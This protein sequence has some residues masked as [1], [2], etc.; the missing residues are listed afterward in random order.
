[1]DGQ[2]YPF[3]NFT[4][5]DRIMDTYIENGTKPLLELGFM[6]EKM[7]KYFTGKGM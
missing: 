5:L 4:Y 7:R 1:M 3:Y 6:P 2:I